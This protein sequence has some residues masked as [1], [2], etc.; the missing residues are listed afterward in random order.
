[1]MVLA[2]H[3]ISQF[4]IDFPYIFHLNYEGNLSKEVSK[5]CQRFWI[6]VISLFSKK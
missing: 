3:A 5:K 6:E 2:G 1:M 4:D